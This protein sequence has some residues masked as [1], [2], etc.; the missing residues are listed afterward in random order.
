MEYT[1]I[2]INLYIYVWTLHM[3]TCMYNSFVISSPY[4]T[5]CTH[6]EFLCNPPRTAQV[7]A[8]FAQNRVFVGTPVS[9]R[10]AMVWMGLRRTG[11]F[12]STDAW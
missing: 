7:S 2:T 9:E 3:I 10:S 1:G 8:D 12:T 6:D 4:M 5:K 11:D